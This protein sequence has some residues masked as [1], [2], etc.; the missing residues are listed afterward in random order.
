MRSIGIDIGE[1][2]VKIV[3][4]IQNKKAVAINQIQEKVLNTNGSPQDRELETIEFMREFMASQDFSNSKF[5]MAVRQDKVTSRF[6]TF[7]FSDKNKIQKSLSFEMEEDIPFDTDACVFE[8]K[9][10]RT[11]GQSADV[12]A[13]AVPKQHV[14]KIISLAADF[15][16]ELNII[17]IEGLAF[18]NL[19]EPWDQTP[20]DIKN[21][22]VIDDIEKPKKNLQ[23]ILNIGH[24]KTL[25]TVFEDNRLI[26]TRSLFWGADQ[27]IQDIVKRFQV[28]VLDASKTLQTQG[29]LL[30]S[31]QGASFEQTQLSDLLSKSLRE[32]VRDVQMTVLE[33][34]SEFNAEISEIHLTGGLS[35]LHNLGA[36][37]TQHL[38]IKCNPVSLL[39]AYAPSI[40]AL[41]LSDKSE[42]IEARFTVAL[43]SALESYKKPR[44][45]ATNLL[46]GEFAKQNNRLKVLWQ[47]WGTVA[48]IAAASLVIL[49]I[50][51]SFRESFTASLAERGDEA[52]ISQ[53][54]TVA[55]LPKKQANE[56]GVKKYIRDNK[57]KAN[58]LKLV[59]QVAQ[60]N[61]ALEVLKK[62]SEAAPGKE[63]IKVDIMT[64]QIKDD[65]VQMI[66][67]ANTPR[68]VNLLAQNLKS[69]TSSG[70]VTQG[71]AN[72]ASIP[73]RVAFNI[74]FKADRGLV[75]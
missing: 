18:A 35:L 64:F 15:G 19:V 55:R 68:E 17:T 52:L 57:K 9:L 73:N 2:S 65:L 7:P 6:K 72:L 60:M 37:L 50:W 32:L 34:Q 41:G 43:G 48:Q 66:G 36:F 54:K 8:S 29:Q 24:R 51:S 20:P 56:S 16:I 10:I 46:K 67:Y 71:Q 12:I 74:T 40:A 11:Q 28:P 47:Q 42:S 38:E 30:L 1:Y 31:K 75:K 49:F 26:F 13:N 14:E 45:P 27:M 21:D 63:Q 23:V 5:V 62:V 61:S 53:A 22:F 70:D 25:F 59:A 44:N 69:L 3:E 58:A 4:L 39:Q 33:L